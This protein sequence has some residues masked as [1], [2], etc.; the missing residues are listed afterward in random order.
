MDALCIHR[1]D[2]DTLINMGSTKTNKLVK[3]QRYEFLSCD[4]IIIVYCVTMISI[5]NKLKQIDIYNLRNMN[6]N[7]PPQV[8]NA[9][10]VNSF[11]IQE[12]FVFITIFILTFVLS[13]GVF[14]K[15]LMNKLIIPFTVIAVL[16]LNFLMR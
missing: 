8:I 1:F 12:I 7:V 6:I 5:W 11:A 9:L 13:E 4:I 14:T 10:M 3:T 2:E 15:L 16:I